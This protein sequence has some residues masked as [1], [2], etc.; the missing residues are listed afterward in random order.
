MS[1]RSLSHHGWAELC[2]QAHE[3]YIGWT[4]DSLRATRV[5]W[6]RAA[7]EPKSAA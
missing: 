7:A 1:L 5:G 3:V 4:I 6:F 2:E